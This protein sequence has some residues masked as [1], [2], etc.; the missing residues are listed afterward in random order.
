MPR[1]AL[2]LV[3]FL[4]TLFANPVLLQLCL[5]LLRHEHS[6]HHRGDQAN[7]EDMV[8]SLTQVF[9]GKNAGTR[10]LAP[11]GYTVNDGN[12]GANY[13]VA[14][15][16]TQATITPAALTIAADDKNRKSAAP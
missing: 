5:G 12:G 11:R 4:G 14:T 16:P 1:G 8:T 2:A 10:T 7:G 6:H 3:V 9:D 13:S 15:L